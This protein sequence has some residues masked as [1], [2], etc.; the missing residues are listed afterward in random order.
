MHV[1]ADLVTGRLHWHTTWPSIPM[2]FF[3]YFNQHCFICSPSDSTLCRRMLGSNPGTVMT[4]ALALRRCNHSAIDLI[5]LYLLLFHC[6]THHQIMY[7]TPW[8]CLAVKNLPSALIYMASHLFVDFFFFFM[9]WCILSFE[10]LFQV[11]FSKSRGCH[12]DLLSLTLTQTHQFWSNAK[13]SSKSTSSRHIV[14]TTVTAIH[15]QNTIFSI[16]CEIIIK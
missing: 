13:T 5:H 4:L 15:I 1:L 11:L 2:G 8:K 6:F 12:S 10:H 14:C 7:H 9:D 3:M 16:V